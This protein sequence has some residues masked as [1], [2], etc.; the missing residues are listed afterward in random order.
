MISFEMTLPFSIFVQDVRICD[1]FFKCCCLSDWLTHTNAVFDLE[2]TP[3]ENSLLTAS[4]D[5]TIVLWDVT[6]EEKLGTFRGHTSSVKTVQYRHTDKCR[7]SSVDI[8]LSPFLA[9]LFNLNLTLKYYILQ[10]VDEYM[11][12]ILY[13]RFIYTSVLD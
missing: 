8:N 5:Q 1:I 13:A 7:H 3:A 11:T 10:I 2:W 6:E 9:F 12:L 4:G